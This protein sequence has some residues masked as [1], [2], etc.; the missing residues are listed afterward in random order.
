MIRLAEKKDLKDIL[1]IYKCA[2]KYMREHGNATQWGKQNPPESTIQDDLIKKQLF[3]WEKDGTIC[4][5][6]A[7]IIG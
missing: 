6:F 4:G 1:M 5:V 3:V 2:R 7:F